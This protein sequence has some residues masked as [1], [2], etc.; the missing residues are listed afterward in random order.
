LA[1][2]KREVFRSQI[3]QKYGIKSK[4]ESES[5]KVLEIINKQDSF[6]VLWFTKQAISLFSFQSLT[7]SNEGGGGGFRSF[8]SSDFF[9]KSNDKPEKKK[10]V[11]LNKTLL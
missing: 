8:V 1:E 4:E 10:T 3:R 9:F 11:R 2:E 5:E 7:K 6:F